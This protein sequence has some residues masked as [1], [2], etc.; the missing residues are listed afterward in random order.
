MTDP[1]VRQHFVEEVIQIIA[2]HD[3]L[4][5]GLV[6]FLDLREIQPCSPGS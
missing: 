6:L 3:V 5:K 4:E 2:A 1:Q